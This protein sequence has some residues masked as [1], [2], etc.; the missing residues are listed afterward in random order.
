MCVGVPR[1]QALV[2]RWGCRALPATEGTCPRSRCQRGQPSP[3]TSGLRVAAGDGSLGSGNVEIRRAALRR[4]RE[5][6]DDA[7]GDG[8]L[9][10]QVD[11]RAELELEAAAQAHG[12]LAVE[13]ADERDPAGEA[14]ADQRRERTRGEPAVLATE[15]GAEV[16]GR[17]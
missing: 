8:D 6:R 7:V 5:R 10:P 17:A 12:D 2:E 4:E 14:A 3:S 16:D 1:P 15:N 11:G 9:E 13:G